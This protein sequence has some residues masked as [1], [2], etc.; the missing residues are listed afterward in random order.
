MTHGVCRFD[1]F[2]SDSLLKE[3]EFIVYHSSI[4]W[5]SG[6][7]KRAEDFKKNILKILKKKIVKRLK[8]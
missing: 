7:S 5:V 6:I 8:I 1:K 4:N 3:N 2:L